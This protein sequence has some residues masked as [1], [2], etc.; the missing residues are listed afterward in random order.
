MLH[1]FFNRKTQLKATYDAQ[2][3]PIRM[4]DCARKII[5]GWTTALQDRR[6]EKI[7]KKKRRVA[8]LTKKAEK[9]RAMREADK[10]RLK[11]KR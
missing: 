11:K 3:Y 8:Y 1:I 4:D 10:E 7:F 2:Y 6:T 9:E 5:P